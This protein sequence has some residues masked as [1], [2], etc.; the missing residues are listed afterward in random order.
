MRSGGVPT[1]LRYTLQLCT[2]ED[3]DY[4]A[5]ELLYHSPQTKGWQS[6]RFCKYPQ[7]IVLRLETSSKIHQIQVLSHEYK[8]ASRM[9]IR[10][11]MP[12]AGEDNPDH[13]NWKLLGHM[14]FDPNERSG[15]CARELKS[16]HV[17]SRGLFLQFSIQRCHIN[18]QNIYNQ[19]G[20]L[21]INIIGEPLPDLS[22]PPGYLEVMQPLEPEPLQS[23][24]A[25]TAM[26]DL[27]LDVNVDPVT[28]SKIR[29]IARLKDLAVAH[30]E[31]DEAKRLK[32]SI[33]HLKVLGQKIAALESRKRTAVDREDYDAAKLLKTDIDKLRSAGEAAAMGSDFRGP[34][35]SAPEEIF[36]RVLSKKSSSVRRESEPQSVTM[37]MNSVP[38]RGSSEDGL[39]IASS[40]HPADESMGSESYHAIPEMASQVSM[41]DKSKHQLYD[42]R[43]AQGRGKYLDNFA[44]GDTEPAPPPP[45]RPQSRPPSAQASGL[46]PPPG[47]PEDLPAPEPLSASLSKKAQAL[48]PFTGEFI[49]CCVY[50]RNWQLRDASIRHMMGTIDSLKGSGNETEAFRTLCRVAIEALEDKVANVF[51]RG[52][53]FFQKLIETFDEQV[54]QRDV[55]QVTGEVLPLLV[56]KTGDN[57]SRLRDSAKE[58]V[59]NLAKRKDTGLR[60]MTQILLK[61]AKKQT[62]W[63]PIMGKLELI[64]ELV[65]ICGISKTGMGF[66]LEPLM[67]FVGKAFNSPNADVRSMA[68][69]VTIEIHKLVGPAVRK[70]LPN[71]VNPKI[72]EQLNR[73]LEGGG[74]Q[75]GETGQPK[76]KK[77]SQKS[78]PNRADNSAQ[79]VQR[80]GS[81]DDPSIYEDEVKNRER[82]LGPNHPDVAESLGNLAIL[83]NQQQDYNKAQP[84]LERALAIYEKSRGREH[85]DVAHTL[86][87]LAVLH[88]EQSRD[89]I[90]RPLLERALKIQEKHLGPD[91]PDVLAIRDVLNGED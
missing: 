48:Y 76:R 73:E 43:P 65:H 57:N 26:A 81:I 90:G 1:K 82:E 4:P 75:G 63:R 21:A 19:V 52:V 32:Q 39:S 27:S 45:A 24:S 17:K 86:T 60:S 36:N 41:A 7:E 59:I 53:G 33:E 23:V 11:G 49:A 51:H 69:V 37:S 29:E 88:L 31:Y 15:F 9:D 87:D 22:M 61:P 71:N 44:S 67:G 83:Y 85:P 56:E 91:H 6:P 64:K 3:S 2:G 28:A 58:L 18:K 77:G 72:M 66:E 30:E 35:K 14:R 78:S 8:I 84:L 25:A 40:R 89:S 5:R 80:S 47:F 62:A 38:P 68:V 20:I 74:F 12:A 46:T 34:K 79:D 10:A 42:D 70:L 13:V 16:V 50:S 54:G 55:Q